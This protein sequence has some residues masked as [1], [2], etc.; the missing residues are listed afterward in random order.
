MKCRISSGSSLIAKVPV[1]GFLVFKGLMLR[2]D[3]YPDSKDLTSLSSQ[4]H[5]LRNLSRERSGLVA[6]CLPR[7]RGAAGSSLISVT[8]LCP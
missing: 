6:E 1:E 4:I 3:L 5:L 8:V 2:P 7:D